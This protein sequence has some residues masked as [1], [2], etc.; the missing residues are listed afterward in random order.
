MR[1][2]L[3]AAFL[4]LAATA[5]ATAQ[6]DKNEVAIT[7]GRTFISDQGSPGAPTP[8]PIVRFGK[9]LSFQGNYARKLRDYQWAA[10]SIEVRQKLSKHRPETLGQASRI[11]GVTPAAV[12]IVNVYVEMRQ[13]AGAS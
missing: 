2:F 4:L 11:P 13:R 8:Y 5:L 10:L 6:E 12:S 3:A 1:K 7:V 9:G